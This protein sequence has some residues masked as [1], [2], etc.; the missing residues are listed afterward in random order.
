MSAPASV[1][2]HQR[3][4]QITLRAILVLVGLVCTVL[5]PLL[6]PGVD[7]LNVLLTP[8]IVGGAAWLALLVMKLGYGRYV[9]HL[10]IFATL[11]A[12]IVGALVFGS[13]RSADGFLFVAAVAGAGI[14]LGRNALIAT[15]LLSFG[16]L[17]ALTY[18]ERSGWLTTPAFGVGINVWL[19]HASTLVVV[20]VMVYYSQARTR[21]ANHRL[22]EELHLRKRTEEERD[23]NMERL[24]RIFNHSPSVMIAQSALTGVI[25]AVNPA[26]ERCYGYRRDQALGR[27][28][29]FLWADQEQRL[30]YMYH[31]L[32]E[33]R[34]EQE[35]VLGRRSDGSTFHALIS[36]EMGEDIDDRL[37]ITTVIDV[38]EQN[39]TYERLRRSE[40]RFAKAFNFSPMNLAITRL[41]DGK[42]LEINTANQ[43]TL[44]I[45]ADL[46]KGKTA[47]ELGAWSEPADRDAFVARLKR[48]GHVH[49][50]ELRIRGRNGLPMDA[51]IWAEPIDIEGEECILTCTIDVTAERQRQ[52]QLFALTRGL[53]LPGGDALFQALTMHMAQ[54]IG[55]D[56][57][58][59]CEL[60]PG[61]HLYTVAV[62][63][64]GAHVPNF[65]FALD[66]APCGVAMTQTE[67]CVYPSGVARAFPLLPQLT[68]ERFE[69]YVGQALRD[70]DGTSIGVLN[71]FWRQPLEL[72]ADARALIA[73]FASRANAELVRMRRDR[74]ILRLNTVLEQRVRI[75]TGELEKLNAE[76]DSFA[77]SV[78]HD[79]KSPLR[80]ID[81]FTRLLQEQ[82]DAR[83]HPDEKR[84]FERVLSATQRMGALITDLL[85]LA[86]VSQGLLD[87]TTTDLSAMAETVLQSEQDK[88]P[89]HRIHW[90]VE[91][92]LICSCDRH[93]V[94]I[95]LEN[96]LGNAVKYS[97]NQA[98]PLIEF[99]R[100]PGTAP[101]ANA[102]FVRDNGV[103]FHMSHADKLFKPFQ[104]LHL[105]DE[106]E[107]T[108]I[109][110]ATVRRI[111]ERHNGSIRAEAAEGAGATFFF[112]LASTPP[113]ADTHLP[114]ATDA[115]A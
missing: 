60:R 55:A 100:Q 4:R 81:G 15:V 38:T 47:M 77:Y 113:Q 14:F 67:L 50:L 96:L 24:T 110:L 89:D 39:D 42:I 84:L 29:A 18:A 40:E 53:A 28:D 17:A 16:A 97:R 85:A 91:P 58:S 102:F 79:L 88:Q 83:L 21:D 73:I 6:Y 37:V 64:D 44:G 105:Q 63:K 19:T 93:L 115:P 103:G 114:H 82:L 75:R 76:L 94:R 35:S 10:V 90:R 78:S 43:V 30:R 26:F 65:G 49:G 109:G 57:V 36:S 107:G 61:R 20:A 46:A 33:R 22:T 56:M 52:A 108:G 111:I 48:D 68:E 1:P 66:D 27:S 80:A 31:L 69:G 23:R 54:A 72:T 32:T 51:K 98:E 62:W 101:E 11:F 87:C 104:R 13:V 12:A 7:N 9:A 45:T 92:G 59:V 34:T 95:V 86:R 112:S 41:S 2:G 70:E 71:A 74:E 5:I 99:G 25:V 3:E 106:F 8:A